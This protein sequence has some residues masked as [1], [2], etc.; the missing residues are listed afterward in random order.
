MNP[1]RKLGIVA[2]AVLL[3]SLTVLAQTGERIID[4]HSDITAH[5]DATLTIEEVMNEARAKNDAKRAA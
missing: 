3:S 1:L 2:P 5:P 4:F